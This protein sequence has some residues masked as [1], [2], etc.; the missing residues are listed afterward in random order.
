MCQTVSYDFVFHPIDFLEFL[1]TFS[2]PT[3]Y[4]KCCGNVYKRRYTATKLFASLNYRDYCA[5]AQVFHYF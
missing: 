4:R 5:V 3:C 1:I 2:A